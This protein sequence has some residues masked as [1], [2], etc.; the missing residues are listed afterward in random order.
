MESDIQRADQTDLID[1]GDIE[2]PLEDDRTEPPTPAAPDNFFGSGKS[3]EDPGAPYPAELRDR[4]AAFSMDVMILYVV[5]WPLMLF[6]RTIALGSTAGPIPAAGTHGMLLNGIF[7]LIAL[8]YFVLGEFVFSATLGKMLCRLSVM[9]TD[10]AEMTFL[11]TLLRNLLRPLDIIL[12]PTLILTGLMEN[13]LWNRRLGDLVA[14]TMVLKRPPRSRKQFALSLEIIA[15]AT[16]RTA[17]FAIDIAI[18]AVLLSGYALLLSPETPISSMIQILFL[19]I[20]LFLFF[21]IPEITS[22]SSPG[23]WLLGLSISSEE[24][25]AADLPSVV[26]RT[27][28]RPFDNNFMGF[29]TVLFSSRK[30]RPGDSSAN[31]VV[32]KTVREIG[33]FFVLLLWLIIS[34]V[35]LYS[36]LNNPYSFMRSGFKINFLPSIDMTASPSSARTERLKDLGIMDFQ[37]SEGI[38]RSPRQPSIYQP[39]ESVYMTFDVDGYILSDG[40][41]WIQEDLSIAYPDGNVGLKL[42]NINDFNSE[43]DRSGAI[44]FENNIALPADAQPGR[45]TVTLSIRDRKANK[46]IKEQRFFYVTPKESSIRGEEPPSDEEPSPTEQAEV[47]EPEEEQ[48]EESEEPENSPLDTQPYEE[49]ENT[50][51]D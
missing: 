12:F 24:G 50:N 47:E 30:Q 4:F 11:S 37:F 13:T 18:L 40:K 6:Y 29:A 2:T 27:L 32:I 20:V 43:L 3:E 22:H 21:A 49:D 7:L 41:A 36:G 39:G 19:P 34:G 51:L 42:E 14:R 17:A 23:K 28:W 9:K 10:A 5:Y 8:L 33:G 46:E 25:F 15:S 26:I 38:H 44:R 16:R 31:T 35:L 45:Y 48:D 1:V